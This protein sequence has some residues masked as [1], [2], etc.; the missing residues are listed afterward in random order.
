MQGEEGFNG[1]GRTELRRMRRQW[2]AEGSGKS[3][4]QWARE[5]SQVGTAAQ[6]WLGKKKDSGS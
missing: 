1:I 3:L 4:K 2:K 6:A 5:N